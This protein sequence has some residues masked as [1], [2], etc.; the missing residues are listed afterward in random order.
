MQGK[1][2]ALRIAEVIKRRY[3]DARVVFFGSRIRG[4]YLKDSDYDI[5][6]VSKAFR[7]KHFTRRSSE[8]LRILWDAGI[9][10]D[11]EILCYTPEEFERKKKNLGIVREALREGVVL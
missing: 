1:A 4:D 2:W 3:P 7:G 11:F 5:I 8:V 10:G 6:V 9:V